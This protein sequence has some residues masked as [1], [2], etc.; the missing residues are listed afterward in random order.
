[1]VIS[2]KENS[3]NSEKPR[4]SEEKG[5]PPNFTLMREFI[6]LVDG[7][8][9]VDVWIHFAEGDWPGLSDNKRGVSRSFLKIL[10]ST[11]SLHT[12]ASAFIRFQILSLMKSHC[13][14]QCSHSQAWLWLINFCGCAEPYSG[15][16]HPVVSDGRRHGFWRFVDRGCSEVAQVWPLIQ[17]FYA[18]LWKII[19][20]SGGQINYPSSRR[21]LLSFILSSYNN[22]YNNLQ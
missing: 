20:F 9:V 8:L 16:S 13:G 4:N 19:G 15:P 12:S 5:M 7:K 3:Q 21:M 11:D 10:H 1:M 18:F 14:S 17:L 2:L 22:L 6:V